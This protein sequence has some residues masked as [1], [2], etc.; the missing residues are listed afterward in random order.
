MRQGNQ[1]RRIEGA[2]RAVKSS[3]RSVCTNLFQ[4][5][6]CVSPEP[7]DDQIKALQILQIL[8]TQC[9]LLHHAFIIVT[10]D[11]VSVLKAHMTQRC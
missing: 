8:I 4:I 11:A 3:R 7:G 5:V 9:K 1:S 6:F 2:L 10:E